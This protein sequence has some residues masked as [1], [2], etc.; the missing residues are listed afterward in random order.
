MFFDQN[1]LQMQQILLQNVKIGSRACPASY[2]V[3][4]S[5][6]VVGA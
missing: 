4:T 6:K 1:F 3:V 2:S 5:S